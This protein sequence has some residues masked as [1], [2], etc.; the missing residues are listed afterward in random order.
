VVDTREVL[1]YPWVARDGLPESA[2]AALTEAFE[3]IEDEELL[4]LMRA[5]RYERVTV[6]EYEELVR[7]AIETGLLTVGS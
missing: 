7:L 2:L 1:G 4:A 6:D 3:A 5:L